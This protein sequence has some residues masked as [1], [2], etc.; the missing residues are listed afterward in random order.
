LLAVLAVYTPLIDFSYLLNMFRI[1]VIKR[2]LKEVVQFLHSQDDMHFGDSVDIR[3]YEK[4]HIL[5]VLSPIY[6]I[7]AISCKNEEGRIYRAD[8]ISRCPRYLLKF[9]DLLMYV[10]VAFVNLLMYV[11][12]I[13]VSVA[14]M[15]HRDTRSEKPHQQYVNCKP[16]Q[17]HYRSGGAQTPVDLCK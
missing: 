10:F 1:N 13:A 5:Q 2:A 7:K 12:V 11:F 9:V 17:A 8:P 3:H 15:G 14:R 6:F 16:L 4:G